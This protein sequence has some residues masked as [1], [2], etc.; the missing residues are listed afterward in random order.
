MLF[1]Q[2]FCSLSKSLQL[3]QQL[4]LFR[5]DILLQ[6]S[7]HFIFPLHFICT[8]TVV[9][10]FSVIVLIHHSLRELANEEIFEI[11]TDVL[12]SEDKKLVLTGYSLFY[13]FIM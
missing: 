3:A 11:L 12:R 5:Y 9:A 10:C 7:D 8:V 4:R 2:E 13:G 6:L 1:L